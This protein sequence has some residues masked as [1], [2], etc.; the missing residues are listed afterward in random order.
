[1]NSHAALPN[2]PAGKFV[3]IEGSVNLRDFGGYLT[4]DGQPVKRGLLFR[5]GSMHAI[6]QHAWHAFEALDIGVICDL[7]GEDEAAASPTPEGPPFACRV[8]IPI[9]P[10]SSTQFQQQTRTSPPTLDDFTAFMRRVTCEIARDH[11]HAYEKVMG[12]LLDTDNGFLIHC[13]AGKDRTGVGA[14]LILSLLGVDRETI[15]HDYLVSNESEELLQRTRERMQQRM[16]EEG[17]NVQ[18]DEHILRV[19]A[20]VKADY[21]DSAFDEIETHYG[22]I[23][24]YLEAAGIGPAEIS[25]IKAKLLE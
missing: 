4:R 1:M 13:T 22:G 12:H 19:M 11:V 14:A 21:L 2:N 9:W 3:A 15:M 25:A 23:E 24:G 18:I 7:R 20:G 17:R 8:H 16:Q 10:G 6:P 5:C